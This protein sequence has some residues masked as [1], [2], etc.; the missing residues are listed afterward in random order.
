MYIRKMMRG[1]AA[2]I[3]AALI[4]QNMTMTVQASDMAVQNEIKLQAQGVQNRATGVNVA[5][6]TQ[7]EINNYVS[8][9]GANITDAVTFRV[10]PVTDVPYFPGMLS[11]ETLDSAV[12]MLNQIRYIAGIPYNVVLDDDY[13]ILAQCASLVN[14]ANN[15]MSHYPEWP[16]GMEEDI[17]IL[18]KEGAKSSNIS[19]GSGMSWTLNHFI[20][21]GWMNDGGSSNIDRV[22]HRRWLLNPSM[23]KTGFGLVNGPSMTHSAV[24]VFDRS[25]KTSEYGVMWPAQNMPVEYFTTKFPW[26]IS[27][28]DSVDISKVHVTM[29]RNS[30]GREWNFSQS[31]DDGAFYVNNDNYGQ[32]GCIIFRP[33]DIE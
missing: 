30:D 9:S 6:R 27:M 24:Y 3:V 32:K 17:Y 2:G 33:D 5:Y 12:R 8:A 20:A 15:K 31:S 14:Y 29:K 21:L 26:S 28:G 7:D 23:Q 22:G 19:W 13:T 1:M 11:E 18:G 25:R 4:L 16:E 10:T